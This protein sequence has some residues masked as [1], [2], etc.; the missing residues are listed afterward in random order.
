MKKEKERATNIECLRILA[1]FFIV[2]SHASV[3]G[4]FDRGENIPLFNRAV[5][6]FLSLGNLGVAIFVMITGYF[7]INMTFRVKKIF[8]LWIQV[9]IYS[10]AFWFIHCVMVHQI[11]LHDLK[12]VIFPVMCGKYGFFCVFFLLYILSPFLNAGLNSLDRQN[13]FRLVLILVLFGS[14][15]PVLVYRDMGNELFRYILYYAIGAYLKRFPDCWLNRSKA[16]GGIV[17]ALFLGLVAAAVLINTPGNRW[18]GR[19][20]TFF[21]LEAPFVIALAACLLALFANIEMKHL[22]FVNRVAGTTFGVYLLHDNYYGKKILW[23]NILD[24]TP[25]AQDYWLG[26]RLLGSAIIVFSACAMI[27][28]FRLF[29]AG[30]LKRILSEAA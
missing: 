18:E 29:L 1:M 14:L 2:C 22:G 30:V 13:F 10:A 26:M 8:R 27:E 15:A 21:S 12:T 11:E 25:Y 5:L 17:F 3:H 23:L 7:N 4:G 24:N 16:K 20:S 28:A 9:V 19:F 6:D